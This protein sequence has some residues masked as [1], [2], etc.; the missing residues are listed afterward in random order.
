MQLIKQQLSQVRATHVPR[1]QIPFFHWNV[2]QIQPLIL[3]ILFLQTNMSCLPPQKNF[4]SACKSGEVRC[5][6]FP[7]TQQDMIWNRPLTAVSFSDSFFKQ[8]LQMSQLFRWYI[9]W[10]FKHVCEYVLWPVER[11]CSDVMCPVDISGLAC[12]HPIPPHPYL[13]LLLP[14]ATTSAK[15]IPT[16]MYKT[17]LPHAKQK[18]IWLLKP[19]WMGQFAQIVCKLWLRPLFTFGQLPWQPVFSLFTF[20]QLLS[21]AASLP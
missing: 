13:P 11:V 2:C 19:L 10:P 18:R 8:D 16:L 4:W 15:L 1:P 17:I 12:F 21:L 7:T 20:G 5:K 6:Y 14:L 3:Q 9:L